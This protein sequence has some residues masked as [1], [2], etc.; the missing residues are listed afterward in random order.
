MPLRGRP[1]RNLYVLRLI[2]VD[3]VIHFLVLAV[4]GVA[5]VLFAG[6]QKDLRGDYIRILNSLQ[7]SIGL[8][9]SHNGFLREINHFVNLSTTKLYLYGIGFCTYAALN[10]IEAV[11]LWREKRWAEY[12]TLTEV[13]LLVPL[14]IY[15]L[16]I[17]VTYL[18]IGALI[19]NLAVMAYLGW[20]HRLFGIRGGGREDRLQYEKDV[21]W[22]ALERATPVISQLPTTRDTTVSERVEPAMSR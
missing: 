15:E 17:S 14:E 18:K 7:S 2:A 22:G 11:G 8:I 13:T 21:G 12:L 3:R 20:A 16:T 9:A 6:H 1:L 10:A 4:L 5:L 19:V